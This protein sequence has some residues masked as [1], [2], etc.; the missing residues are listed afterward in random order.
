MLICCSYEIHDMQAVVISAGLSECIILI[1]VL[2]KSSVEFVFPSSFPAALIEE[3]VCENRWPLTC[4]RL[5]LRNHKS[6]F[7][8]SRRGQRFYHAVRWVTELTFS[9]PLGWMKLIKLLFRSLSS[10]QMDPVQKAV[11]HHTFSAASSSKRK[12]V[13][14][15]VCQ[16]RFNSQVSSLHRDPDVLA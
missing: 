8:W 15:G 12:A 6:C 5:R 16:L 2:M 11:L 1:R 13:S 9:T 3:R 7:W 10:P 14:C 4:S